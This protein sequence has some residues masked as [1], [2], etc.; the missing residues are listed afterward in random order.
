MKLDFGTAGIRGIVGNDIN[1]LNEAHAAR[2]FDG[3]AKYLIKNFN[4]AKT[5]GVVIGRDNRIKGKEFANIAKNILISYGIKVYFNNQMLATPFISYVTKIKNAIGAINITASHNPKEYNGIKIY[6]STGCQI[7]PNAVEQIKLEFL[8]YDNYLSYLNYN[9]N[10]QKHLE[11]S[12]NL[13]NSITERDF[14]MYIDEIQ[15][16]NF[17]KQDLS[18]IKIVYSSLHGTGYKYVNYLLN[19]NNANVIFEKNEIIE[20]KNFT[21]V[22]NPNPENKDAFQNTIKLMNEEN[23]DLILITDPDADRVGVALKNKNNDF[24]L[25]NGNET[26][27][28]ITD[29]LL[30]FKPL[31]SNKN[32]YLIYSFV[33]TSLPAKMCHLKKIKSYIV[34]TGFKWI[35][36]QINNLKNKEEFFFGF[37]ESYGSLINENLSNDKDAIQALFALAIIAS[38]AKEYNQTLLDKLNEIYETYGFMES[39]SNSFDLIDDQHLQS[40]IN[41]FKN[42]DIPNTELI[43]YNLGIDDIEPTNMLMYKFNDNYSWVS[44]RPSGTEPKIKLYI[45]IISSTKLEA[46]QKYDELYSLIT[47]QLNL[48]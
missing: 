23:A 31:I 42:I 47:K 28:L 4:D 22:K 30:K 1:C 37:E 38:K 3:Y 14:E 10:E 9:E 12:L 43:D 19:L 7:L 18:N 16:I 39:K 40:I 48:I 35:G 24:I 15:K 46:K 11:S 27:I 32:Y 20:D 5:R 25:L 21:Y 17:T 36:A 8:D 29:Y 13:I 2:V 41:K 44:L 45:H 6:D 34:E 33:S 26:A